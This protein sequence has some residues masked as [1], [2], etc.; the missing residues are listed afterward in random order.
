MVEGDVVV[1]GCVVDGCAVP[2]LVVG[3]PVVPGTEFGDT[4]G[5]PAL[6]LPGVTGDVDGVFNGVVGGTVVCGVVVLGTVPFTLG[7]ASVRGVWVRLGMVG[8]LLERLLAL[9]FVR[10]LSACVPV[11]VGDVVVGVVVVGTVVLLVVVGCTWACA[12]PNVSTAPSVINTF[13]MT[14]RFLVYFDSIKLTGYY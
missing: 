3:E 11:V 10:V 13:F 1:P 5:L 7:A 12:I 8:S 2:G 9:G 14:F 6:V 4:P